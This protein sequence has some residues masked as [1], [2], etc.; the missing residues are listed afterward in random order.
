MGSERSIVGKTFHK[1][2]TLLI[3]EKM[4]GC[5]IRTEICGGSVCWHEKVLM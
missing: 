5:R 3:K 2:G 1:R 4:M